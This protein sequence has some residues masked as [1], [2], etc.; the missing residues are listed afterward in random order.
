[1]DKDGKYTVGVYPTI[2]DTSN[3]YRIRA[4]PP[5][6]WRQNLIG[7]KQSTYISKSQTI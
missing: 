5:R 6:K 3:L 7:A 2:T 4:Q 1:M